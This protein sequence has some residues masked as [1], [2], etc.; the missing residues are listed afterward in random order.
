MTFLVIV[1]IVTAMAFEPS[2]YWNYGYVGSKH[3]F[4]P[5]NPH[6]PDRLNSLKLWV[7]IRGVRWP[8]PLYMKLA[9]SARQRRNDGEPRATSYRLQY[10]YPMHDEIQ[11][12]DNT[13]CP[14]WTD[15]Q[16]AQAQ[17]TDTCFII[18]RTCL[19]SNPRN[20]CVLTDYYEICRSWNY[21]LL[22]SVSIW[23]V[24]FP[25]TSWYRKYI[26]IFEGKVHLLFIELWAVIQ[27]PWGLP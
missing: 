5:G 17:A 13:Y 16:R 11:R 14:R 26:R 25:I 20:G 6:V 1:S 10:I 19:G 4:N 12:V 2:C 27:N 21:A 18:L 24:S 8:L 3:S 22:L 9:K 15:V 23:L 7:Y